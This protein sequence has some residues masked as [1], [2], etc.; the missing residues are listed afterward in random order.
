[1]PRSTVRCPQASRLDQ[2]GHTMRNGIIKRCGC[3]D[4]DGRKLGRRCRKLSSPR[5]GAWYYVAELPPRSDGRRRRLLRGGFRTAKDA[6]TERHAAESLL[7]FAPHDDHDTVERVVALLLTTKNGQPLPDHED[8]RRKLGAGVSLTRHETVS[9]YLDG[10]ISHHGMAPSTLNG[11]RRHIHWWKGEVGSIRLDRL[12]VAHVTPAFSQ[13]RDSGVSAAT[14]QRYRATLRSALNDAVREQRIMV[15]PAALVK[16]PSGKA[17]KPVV[18]TAT[19]I[20]KWRADLAAR[21]QAEKVDPGL[22]RARND[23]PIWEFVTRP[24]VAVWPP[25]LVGN[26]S[27]RRR[28]TGSPHSGMSPALRDYDA[29]SCVGWSGLMWTWR[30]RR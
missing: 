28:A 21:I 24:K 27:M 1:M 29:E 20:E 13:L 16:L 26:S 11:Y 15:N 2:R 10:W 18:W 14:V 9:E 22:G 3:R 8:V 6:L 12:R 17:P 4:K 23:R 5:H 25:Q 7:Q 19:R 30:P